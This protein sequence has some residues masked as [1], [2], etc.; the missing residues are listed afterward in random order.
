MKGIV[1]TK[2]VEMVEE[3]FSVG[4][5]S[6]M[7]DSSDLA[8][9]GAYTAVGTYDHAEMAALVTRLSELTGQPVPELLK[10]YGRFLFGQF[11]RL[12]PVFFEG[13][14][15]SIE[16]SSRI[17]GVIHVEV[18]KLYPDAE[19][20]S[21]EVLEH[22]PERLRMVYRSERHL[23][24][25]AEGLLDACIAHFGERESVSLQ[26]ENLNEPGAPVCFTLIR[27]I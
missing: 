5:A 27:K 7:I 11:A 16:F 25:L 26:R 10:A 23:G 22:T 12:Y 8:S 24:D 18:K 1:F 9:G 14:L 3:Q 19:L 15:G 17:E 6:Q 20:P 4:I 13:V 21:F 2:F